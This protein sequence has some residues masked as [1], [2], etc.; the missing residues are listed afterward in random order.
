MYERQHKVKVEIE[1]SEEHS[2]WWEQKLVDPPFLGPQPWQS[3]L[4]WLSA[5]RGKPR[6]RQKKGR[7]R[8]LGGW[9][10]GVQWRR[11]IAER[12]K[13]R[14]R[15]E[16][17]GVPCETG[18]NSF[19]NG[20]PNKAVCRPLLLSSPCVT[21][22]MD[23]ANDAR[24]ESH[25]PVHTYTCRRRYTERCTCAHSHTTA[26]KTRTRTPTSFSNPPPIAH[27]NIVSKKSSTTNTATTTTRHNESCPK[28]SYATSSTTGR[29]PFPPRPCPL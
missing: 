19:S 29:P 1:G 18:D 27:H 24:N 8:K 10:K 26:H 25:S 20:F 22:P 7:P 13:S 16:M 2:T 28:F 21:G 11:R 15:M 3:F 17:W 6:K 12:Q 5:A 4:P 9:R 14:E 23:S